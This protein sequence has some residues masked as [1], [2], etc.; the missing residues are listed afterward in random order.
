MSFRAIVFGSKQVTYL[1]KFHSI[2][3]MFRYGGPETQQ[4][5]E[6]F[7]L[8]WS[9][10]L[11]SSESVIYASIDGRGSSGRGYRFMHEIYHHLG[12]AEV[13]DQIE[14]TK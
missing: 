7:K 1:V 4:V 8:D 12:M 9:T 10:F 3:E 2:I 6:E 14:G 13:Q 11:C 5:T